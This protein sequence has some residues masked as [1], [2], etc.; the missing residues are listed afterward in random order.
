MLCVRGMEA[1][2]TAKAARYETALEQISTDTSYW[3]GEIARTALDRGGDGDMDD[4]PLYDAENEDTPPIEPLG[5]L[6][7]PDEVPPEAFEPYAP[8]E[9]VPKQPDTISFEQQVQRAGYDWVEGHWRK[10]PSKHAWGAA[11]DIDLKKSNWYGD[12]PVPAEPALLLLVGTALVLIG[13]AIA[14]A[15]EGYSPFVRA[16]FSGLWISLGSAA[17]AGG[18]FK[19]VE[20]ARTKK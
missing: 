6:T 20:E 7:Y 19:F 8:T 9:P 15:T 5:D 13:L 17:I 10:Q 12:K 1:K 3:Q 4:K 11:V 2:L 18:V 16:L 14:L